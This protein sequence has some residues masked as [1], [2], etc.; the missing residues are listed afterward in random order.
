MTDRFAVYYRNALK[1]A[2]AIEAAPLEEGVDPADLYHPFLSRRVYFTAAEAVITASW[3]A[4]NF[5]DSV[6]LAACVF[7]QARITVKEQGETLFSGWMYPQGKNSAFTLPSIMPCDELTVEIF[8]GAP[9]SVGWMFAGLRTLFPRFQIAPKTGLEVTGSAERT[10][11]GQ[12]YG[13]KRPT[14]ETLDVS[15][16]RIDRDTRRAMAE[17]IDAV[18]FVEPHLIEAYNAE[19]WPLLYGVLTGAGDFSKRDGP[20]FYFDTTMAWKEAG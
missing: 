13:L 16:A 15:F 20:G 17:Y 7:T 18:Q 8:A 9:V 14:L 12:V 1:N 19:V 3:G 10:E 5:I 6:C 2:A 4:G 11:G